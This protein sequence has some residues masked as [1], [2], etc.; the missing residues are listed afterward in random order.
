MIEIVKSKG[1]ANPPKVG[2]TAAALTDGPAA[3]RG[4]VPSATGYLRLMGGPEQNSRS[5]GA[6]P[7]GGEWKLAWQAPLDGAAGAALV[8]GNRIVVQ[9]GGGWTLFSRDGKQVAQGLAGGA[10][11]AV[12]PS[13]GMFYAVGAGFMLEALAL[14]NGELRFKIPLGHNESFAWRLLYRAGNHIIAAAVEQKMLSPKGYPPTQSL[15]QAIAVATPPKVSPYKI[16]LSIDSQDELIFKNPAMLPVA[17]RSILWAVLPNLLVR[18][19]S[20]QE[21]GGA[22]SD[23]FDPVAASADEAGWLHLVAGIG[24]RREL[25]IVTPEGRRTARVPLPPERREVAGPPAI[26]FDRRVYLWSARR[27][28]AFAPDGGHLWDAAVEGATAGLTVT[29]NGYVVAGGG[30]GVSLVDTAGKVSKVLLDDRI[31]APP[32]ITAEGEL[33]VGG[34]SKLLCYRR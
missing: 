29:P 19:S 34:E 3:P 26:G 11:I 21:V 16:L 18:T 32:V 25:W 23:T 2:Y 20:S 13:S 22:W 10:P 5:P 15:I 6:L 8:S 9:Q 12:D 1:E 33:I 14:E 17:S 4:G 24:E 31:T 28:S 30:R 27:V 7:A